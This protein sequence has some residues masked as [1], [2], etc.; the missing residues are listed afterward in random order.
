[1]SMHTARETRTGQATYGFKEFEK[2]GFSA[3]T[4]ANPTYV[5]LTGVT[6]G[7]QLNL[8]N[9][10][11]NF[12]RTVTLTSAAA[13]AGISIITDAEVPAGRKVYITQFYANVAGATNWATTATVKIQDTNGTPVDFATFAVAAMTGNS[14]LYMNTANVT[15]EVAR[16]RMT[17]GTAA[18]GI[19]A[20]GD[21]NGTGS[22]FIVTVIGFIA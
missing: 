8:D 22:D 4:S 19:R 9:G 10:R 15:D 20:I 18:K 11:Y 3:D 5:D 21:A 6:E 7:I 2:A 13:A 12:V 1:M 16:I 17:G 14:K